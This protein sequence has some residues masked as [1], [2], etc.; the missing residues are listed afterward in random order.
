MKRYVFV[1]AA[2]FA[3]VL[4][5]GI[6]IFN[7]KVN[8]LSPWKGGGFGMFSTTDNAVRRLLRVYLVTSE[9]D[10][11]ILDPQLGSS[12]IRLRTMPTDK[13][14]K[15]AAMQIAEAEWSIYRYDQYQDAITELPQPLQAYLVKKGVISLHGKNRADTTEVGAD[16][17]ETSEFYPRL[18]A[19][20]R[21]DTVAARDGEQSVYGV[22]I[23]IWKPH[24]D[25]NKSEMSFDKLNEVIFN[26]NKVDPDE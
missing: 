17:D 21:S 5:A 13:V 10:A 7:A 16:E 14:L 8:D 11:L 24:F 6:Q 22:R 19:L 9:G 1:F 23:E 25:P 12:L 2:P 15:K 4:I 20:P 26:M 3:L 18:I